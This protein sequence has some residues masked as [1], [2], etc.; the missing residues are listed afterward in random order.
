MRTEIFAGARLADDE[1]AQAA[2]KAF[3]AAGE[4]SDHPRAWTAKG[5]VPEEERRGGNDGS[6]GDEEGRM[7]V[8][9]TPR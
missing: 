3:V 4:V 8:K 9:E 6:E 7:T 5:S 1:L 2:T